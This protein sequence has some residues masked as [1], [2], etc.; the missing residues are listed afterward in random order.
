MEARGMDPITLAGAAVALV[1]PY[2][3]EGGKELGKKV[4]GEAGERIV[5]LYD[6]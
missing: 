2:L 4:G 1:A 6:K 3:A 5:K